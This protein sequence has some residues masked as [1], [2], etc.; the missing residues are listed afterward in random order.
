MLF[1]SA[2]SWSSPPE[3]QV[4][5]NVCCIYVVVPCF[6]RDPVYVLWNV[7]EV[8]HIIPVFAG[9]HC[10]VNLARTAAG[11]NDATLDGRDREIRDRS[12][13]SCGS[14]WCRRRC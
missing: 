13:W 10:V 11:P 4:P 1:G 6:D 9:I 12:T 5:N 2:W 3:G 14:C 8:R 7:R